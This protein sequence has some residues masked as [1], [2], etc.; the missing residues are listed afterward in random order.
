MVRSPALPEGRTRAEKARRT[1]SIF[2]ATGSIGR[3]TA[4][5][6]LQHRESFDVDVVTAQ[7][8]VEELAQTAIQLGAR[9]AV[10][11]D[12]TLYETLRARLAGTGIAVAAGQ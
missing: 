11:G 12:A 10:I 8:R 1:L 6:V 9:L 5:V 2:G 7:S 3:S 4:D